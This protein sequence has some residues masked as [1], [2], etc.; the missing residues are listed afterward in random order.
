MPHPL[1]QGP[2]VIQ[3]DDLRTFGPH[4]LRA[5][6]LSATVERRDQATA[7]LDRFVDLVNDRSARAMTRGRGAVSVCFWVD[8]DALVAT[9]ADRGGG[10][11]RVVSVSPVPEKDPRQPQ[12]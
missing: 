7:G 4:R 3:I 8:A 12:P 10:F 9:V 5:C 1:E 2:P 11:D 6:L